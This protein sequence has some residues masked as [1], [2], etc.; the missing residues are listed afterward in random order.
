MDYKNG[1]E[2]ESSALLRH[3]FPLKLALINLLVRI[4]VSVP[5]RKASCQ[6]KVAVVKILAKS[7]LILR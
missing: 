2:T 1:V 4:Q 7:I 5:T 3:F 6:F